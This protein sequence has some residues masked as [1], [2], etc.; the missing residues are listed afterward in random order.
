MPSRPS[1]SMPTKR[2]IDEAYAAASALCPDVRIKCIGPDGVT[3]DYPDNT[4]SKSKWHDKPF[5]GDV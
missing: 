5:S 4:T 2:Q 3:F 1:P